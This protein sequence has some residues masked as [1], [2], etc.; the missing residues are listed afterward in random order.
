MHCC[1]TVSGPANTDPAF[2]SVLTVKFTMPALW[3]T[4]RPERVPMLAIGPT[5][6]TNTFR[7]QAAASATAA[8]VGSGTAPSWPIRAEPNEP[9]TD[10]DALPQ[11]GSTRT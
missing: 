6:R 3:S 4:A 7:G 11:G 5:T 2:D 10:A 9:A 8:A 1:P